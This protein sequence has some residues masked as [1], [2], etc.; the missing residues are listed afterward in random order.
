MR[1]TWNKWVIAVLGAALVA[2]PG[3]MAHT[4]TVG[5]VCGGVGGGDKGDVAD[6]C[7][8]QEAVDAAH[9]DGG[10]EV[11]IMPG[12]YRE[13]VVLYEQVKVSA[14]DPG[15]VIELPV[16]AQVEALMVM[17]N[18]TSV[19]GITL[20][21][22]EGAGAGIPLVLIAGVEDVGMEE[23]VLDGGMNRGSI[24]VYVQSQLLETS[25]IRNST[26]RR[27]EVGMLVE[28]ARFRITRCLF[29]DIL[30]DGIYARPPGSLL[31]GEDEFEAPEVG[32]E[33]DLELSG[34]N[35]FRNI[36]GFMDAENQPINPGDAFL[37]R[38]TTGTVLRAQLNDWGFYE[39]G[40]IGALVSDQPPGAAKAKGV[41]T[42]AADTVVFEPFLGKSL[43]PGSVFVRLRDSVSLASLVDGNPRLL[44]TGV[45]TQ[46][47][48]ALDTVSKL[49]SF[50][51]INPSTYTVLGQA[52]AHDAA[53]RAG[54][55]VGPG[56][57]VAL[58]L[59]LAPNGAPP[60]HTTDRDAD[61]KISL[62]ELLRVIQFY[63]SF[64]LHCDAAGEDGYAP[65][66]GAQAGCAAHAADY[67]PQDW[68]VSL[69]EL[70]RVIQ[71]YNSDGYFACVGSEDGYCPGAPL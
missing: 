25:Q 15:V 16:G 70:V 40:S 33:D 47:E 4:Y 14:S 28:D 49:Y 42:K 19:E 51:F 55:V 31:K 32:D 20:R 68:V 43:F 36:G 10:G 50:T 3:A 11:E 38:N 30:R 29:E 17:A 37:L 46:I 2:G 39:S 67:A 23:I 26:V 65:G 69:D 57:I 24:G 6:F 45:D 66:P 18:K 53:T 71:L 54:V 12:V 64:A 9:A 41:T 56:A 60:T 35:R 5:P 62:D 44:L 22:P 61:G 21:L 1:P 27:V 58:E 34:F 7:S 63:N 52:P 59:A 8:V 48:P 13:S